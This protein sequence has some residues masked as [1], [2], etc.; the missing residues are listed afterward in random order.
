[1]SKGGDVPKNTT[2]VPLINSLPPPPTLRNWIDLNNV[3]IDTTV[4]YNYKLSS[5]FLLTKY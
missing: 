4:M 2:A 3:F 5:L 1:M